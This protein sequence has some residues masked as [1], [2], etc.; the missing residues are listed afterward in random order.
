MNRRRICNCRMAIRVLAADAEE[1]WDGDQIARPF[2]DDATPRGASLRSPAGIHG[3]GLADRGCS[4]ARGV[5]AL[6]RM[7]P[8][9]RAQ[10]RVEAASTVA[11]GVE[12]GGVIPR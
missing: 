10:R 6:D 7:L 11:N 3:A 9:L 1:G 8:A 4:L 2:K 12:P 5:P